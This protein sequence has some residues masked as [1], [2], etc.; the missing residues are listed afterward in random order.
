MLWEELC[1]S[2]IPHHTTICAQGIHVWEEHLDK[3]QDKMEVY[4]L[5]LFIL[6][7]VLICNT[8]KAM[9]KISTTMDMWSDPN[10]FPFMALTA[11]WIQAKTVQTP[12]SPQHIFTLRADL[13]SFLLIPGCHDGKHLTHV[14]LYFTDWIGIMHNISYLLFVCTFVF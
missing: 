10:L 7:H 5:I 2:D 3:L 12:D 11:H 6:T 14:F 8:Q 4:I 1:D 9:S 13:I